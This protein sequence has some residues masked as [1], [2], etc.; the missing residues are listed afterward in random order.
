MEYCPSA[1][2]PIPSTI[3]KALVDWRLQSRPPEAGLLAVGEA[4][5]RSHQV[6]QRSGRS[7]PWQRPALTHTQRD[8]QHIWWPS[9]AKDLRRGRGM[10]QATAQ[11]GKLGS[12]PPR[13]D[14]SVE[15]LPFESAATPLH[16]A[17]H[18]EMARAARFRWTAGAGGLCCLCRRCCFHDPGG[19]EEAGLAWEKTTARGCPA[20]C[21]GCSPLS[22]LPA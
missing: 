20:F 9:N 21:R 15:C 8:P 19:C 7:G 2:L 6:T 14:C 18:S 13:G 11:G 16:Q 17:C 12:A 3:V 10:G 22:S 4:W 5:K 1:H